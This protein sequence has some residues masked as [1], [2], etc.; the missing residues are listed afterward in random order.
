MERWEP[1]HSDTPVIVHSAPGEFHRAQALGAYL[2]ASA[3][4][5]FSVPP[6]PDGATGTGSGFGA[7]KA[8]ASTAPTRSMIPQVMNA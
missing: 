2:T 3:L 4:P 7:R 6:G 8:N 5:G 1:Q